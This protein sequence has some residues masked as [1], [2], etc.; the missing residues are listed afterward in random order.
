MDTNVNL[1]RGS[2]APGQAENESTGT[3][4]QAGVKVLAQVAPGPRF[5]EASA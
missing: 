5:I 4:A 1:K 3:A 2:A